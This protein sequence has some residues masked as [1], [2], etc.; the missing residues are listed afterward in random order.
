MEDKGFLWLC[1]VLSSARSRTQVLETVFFRAGTVDSW[2]ITDTTGCVKRKNGGEEEDVTTY[3]GAL[4]YFL[5]RLRLQRGAPSSVPLC[6]TF[7]KGLRNVLDS[8]QAED[9]LTKRDSSALRCAFIQEY[10]EPRGK[11]T[12]VYRTKY[13][14]GT[15]YT[16]ELTQNMPGM[17]EK[18]TNSRIR[19]KVRDVQQ[20]ILAAIERVKTKRV[21]ELELEFLQDQEGTLWLMGC[22]KCRIAA[23]HLCSSKELP[24]IRS[25]DRGSEKLFKERAALNAKL[26][27]AK[28]IFK[29]GQLR[30]QISNLNSPLRILS[31]DSSP[32]PQPSQLEFN[33]KVSPSKLSK[34][35][36]FH[37][38][39]FQEL[40]LLQL[41]KKNRQRPWLVGDKDSLQRYLDAEG[42]YESGGKYHTSRFKLDDDARKYTDSSR[43]MS[44]DKG[45][46][47]IAQ[48]SPDTDATKSPTFAPI[49]IKFKPP[50]QT[51]PSTT[52]S[53][54]IKSR[55]KRHP[56]TAISATRNRAR[57]MLTPV[58]RQRSKKQVRR[59]QELY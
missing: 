24:A 3:A 6:F 59:R 23:P 38:A 22:L 7:W 13:A 30:N 40:L 57:W 18:V 17:Q 37:N 28:Y 25:D 42:E 32:E 4:T 52:P 20:V 45:D 34:S 8:V 35:A 14:Q 10:K 19:H 2:V 16:S 15:G 53:N 5:A 31:P 21:L 55:R 49:P 47:S 54:P 1:R 58:L 9:F 26:N 46:F 39:N 43:S 27:E 41:A 11:R 51:H 33:E 29:K 44:S 48:F 56:G 36:R 12:Y 50:P